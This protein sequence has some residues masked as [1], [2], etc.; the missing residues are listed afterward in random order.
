MPESVR[1]AKITEA[2]STGANTCLRPQSLPDN[3]FRDSVQI[4]T[5]AQ[6]KSKE[7]W[8]KIKEQSSSEKPSPKTQAE[9]GIEVLQLSPNA[10]MD[11]IRKAY[12]SA[13]KQYHPD[14]FAGFSP[15][16][17]QLAEEKS[18]QINLAYK[19]LTGAQRLYDP[20]R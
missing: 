19:K 8:L 6:E 4:S 11:Q 18:K 15:E 13:I 14:N 2:Y 3:P 20:V 5:E 16:F 1:F 12:L 17:R 9:N 10:T 7:L